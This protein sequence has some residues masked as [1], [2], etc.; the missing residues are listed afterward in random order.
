[1]IG[2]RADLLI[3]AGLLSLGLTAF[4]DRG[5]RTEGLLHAAASILLGLVLL[6][7]I[8]EGLTFDGPAVASWILLVAVCAHLWRG[9]SILSRLK[10]RPTAVVVPLLFGALLVYLWEVLTL[11]FEVPRILPIGTASCRGRVCRSV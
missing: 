6:V 8:R 5:S 11:G 4:A 7:A 10:G 9:M 3:A 1:M 2:P